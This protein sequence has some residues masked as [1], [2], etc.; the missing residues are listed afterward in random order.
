MIVY[1][2]SLSFLFKKK[3]LKYLLVVNY[4]KPNQA[5]LSELHLMFYLAVIQTTRLHQV[6][7]THLLLPQ[8]FCKPAEEIQQIGLVTALLF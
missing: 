4:F 2:G 6:P 7:P 5:H 8:E 1:S 3:V